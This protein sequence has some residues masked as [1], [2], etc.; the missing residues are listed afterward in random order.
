MVDLTDQEKEILTIEDL[1][2]QYAGAKEKAIRDKLDMSAFQFY[3]VLNALIDTE[4]ALAHNPNLVKRLR[5]RR[6][7]R[8]RSRSARR[9]ASGT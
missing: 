6:D 8:Q 4:A 3:Q 2:W 1:W 9:L 5:A 7:E